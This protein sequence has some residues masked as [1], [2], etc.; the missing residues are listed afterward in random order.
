M[1]RIGRRALENLRELV[2]DFAA[3]DVVADRF[4]LREVLG[5][6]GGG[7]VF[8]AIDR[9][10]GREV[11]LKVVPADR[12]VDA[13]RFDREVD[14]LGR[15]AHPAIARYVAHGTHASYRFIATE[16]LAG[17]TL[18]ERL[19]RGPLAL[20][21][22]IELGQRLTEALS[23][24]HRE[25]LAHRDVK[26]SNVFLGTASPANAVLLDFG[27]ATGRGDSITAKG[28]LVG[29]P[30]YMAPEQVRG[31]SPVGPPADVFALGTLLYECLAGRAAFH[32]ATT[33]ILLTKVLLESPEALQSF[34][35]DAPPSLVA[36]V[37]RMMAKREDERP[38]ADDVRT[39]LRAIEGELA[40]KTETAEGW[41]ATLVGTVI[42]GKYRV[43][44]RIG[45]GGMGV[46]FAARHLELGTRVAIKLLRDTAGRE[47]EARFLREARAA[48]QLDSEHVVR[49]LDVGRL[50]ERTP[51]I[52]MEYLEGK[53][54]ACR[55]DGGHMEVAEAVG[56]VLEACEAI[57]QAHLAG[58]VHRD[59][60]PSNL[61]VATRK[62]GTTTVKVLD[63][64]ISK[65][66]RPLEGDEGAISMTEARSVVG[67]A[68]YMSPEQLQSAK[69]VDPRTDIWSLGVV[70]YELLCGARPFEEKSAAAIGAAIATAE[71][72]SLCARASHV[73][74]ELER[75][76]RRCLEKK[77][78]Q[79]YASVEEL[80]RALLPFCPFGRASLERVSHLF[81]SSNAGTSESSSRLT[82]RS[83]P[84]VL[85]FAPLVLGVVAAVLWLRV[86]SPAAPPLPV[87]LPAVVSAP[88]RPPDPAEASISL[89]SSPAP[90]ELSVSA[91]TPS[92]RPEK[93]PTQASR[94]T[95]RAAPP[96][97]A[98]GA[99]RASPVVDI[100]DPALEAR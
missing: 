9:T 32:A 92:A 14:A 15:L 68:G 4:E 95:R 2:R 96:A 62:D 63:F 78:D 67:S 31:S 91:P 60:K 39:S 5:A 43:E 97:S 44:S 36:L 30:G 88:P 57:A 55:L 93:L 24:V 81:G 75:V 35:S 25:G 85:V 20:S 58:I 51:F 73:P 83:R 16:R 70:L 87:G 8:A 86:P 29:T 52:V 72:A 27:L 37:G 71:P 46:V 45:E 49:V 13:A 56:M 89:G 65:I 19:A 74:R 80:A 7:Q 64:G 1:T 6:G 3:G 23:A 90:P 18:T 100:R 28:A 53:D 26:P 41:T 47:D 11:A 66:T 61:F 38:T 17:C 40:A 99:S 76:I 84:R 82:R 12:T 42:A 34:R 54:L 59:I 79:R 21:Q 69:G 77:P 22:V 48:A 10:S 98:S 33:E 94:P 50:D